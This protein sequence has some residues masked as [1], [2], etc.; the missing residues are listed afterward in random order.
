MVQIIAF[1]VQEGH[2]WEEPMWT[3]LNVTVE[4]DGHR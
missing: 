3:E 2:H 1:F 4:H